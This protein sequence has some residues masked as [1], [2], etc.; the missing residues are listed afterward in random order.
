[1]THQYGVLED[2][3][4][5]NVILAES[6]EIA[7]EVIGKDCVFIATDNEAGIGWRWDGEAFTD[8]RPKPTTEGSTPT[9]DVPVVE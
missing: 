7:E 6:K 2:G 4:I 9:E 8:P 1:M 5:I 3:F